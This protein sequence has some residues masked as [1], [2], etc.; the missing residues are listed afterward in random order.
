MRVAAFSGHERECRCQMD[1]DLRPTFSEHL[2]LEVFLALRETFFDVR[3]GP[4][5]FLLRDKRNTQDDPLDEHI[6]QV[7]TRSLTSA[8]CLRAP[9]PL[10]TPDMV[11]ARVD[12]C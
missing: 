6:A 10:I 2:G 4:V 1:D 3:G 5:P 11:I 7:L 12:A 8:T 9:G